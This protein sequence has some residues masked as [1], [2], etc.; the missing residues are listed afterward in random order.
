MSPTCRLLA[1]Q[2]AIP[3][4]SSVGERDR[5][6]EETARKIRERL[7]REPV[8]LV[9]LPELS[10]IDYS[11]AAFDNLEA[12]AEPLDGP[13]FEVLRELARDFGV[14]IVYGIPRR[15]E[16]DYRISQVAVGADGEI[17]GF[18]DKLHVA[19]YGASI[20]K[21]YFARGEHLFVF[22]HEGIKIAPIICYDIR[23]PELTRTLVL[24]H[25]AQLILHCGAYSRDESFYSWHDFVVSRAMENQVY[26]LSLNRAGADFGNSLFCGPWVD[27]NAPAVAFPAFE[28]AMLTLEVDPTRIET[29]RK[30]YSFLSDRLEDYGALGEFAPGSHPG[31]LATGEPNAKSRRNLG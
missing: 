18:F 26:M 6:L 30:R 20:E 2:L 1:C 22:E 31:D 7:A 27:E 15:G 14:A 12:L 4:V 11:R 23:I 9:V 28:E 25:G 5:H 17:I 16:G 19:Q 8:D 21:E 24:R 29:I 13:S 10:G 3:C